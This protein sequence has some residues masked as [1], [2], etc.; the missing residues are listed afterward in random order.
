MIGG[1]KAILTLSKEENRVG[2]GTDQQFHCLPL[3]MPQGS[4]ED[5]AK[6]EEEGGYQTLQGFSKQVRLTHLEPAPEPPQDP[7]A[8]PSQDPAVELASKETFYEEK[9]LEY[10]SQCAE[11]FNNPQMGGVAFSL[12]HSI[13]LEVAK[14]EY[15][16][17]TALREPDQM[18]LTRIGMVFYQHSSLNYKDHGIR[19]HSVMENDATHQV[20]QVSAERVCAQL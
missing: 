13:L 15:H 19:A 6:M 20:L 17:T 18:N 2:Q 4:D 7:A 8:K 1:Y 3:Y 14:H 12:P 5:L 9:V 10:K 16:A 11:A